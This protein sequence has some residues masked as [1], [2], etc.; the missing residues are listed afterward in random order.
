MTAGS[1]FDMLYVLDGAKLAWDIGGITLAKD[2]DGETFAG[3]YT[4]SRKPSRATRD[5]SCCSAGIAC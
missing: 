4:A 2:F 1:S 5:A 3:A